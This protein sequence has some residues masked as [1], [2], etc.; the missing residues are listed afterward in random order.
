MAIMV[1]GNSVNMEKNLM[2][3]N[4][5]PIYKQIYHF[6]TKHTLENGLNPPTEIQIGEH[7]GF[8]REYARQMMN[9]ME[10]E[11]YIFR[12]KKSRVF[13]AWNIERF[14]DKNQCK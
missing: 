6:Y 5:K 3:K 10:K 13:W 9:E 1:L 4:M 11:G 2:N 12:L 8:T 14:T 7:F